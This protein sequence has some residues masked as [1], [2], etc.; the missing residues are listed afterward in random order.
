[1]DNVTTPPMNLEDAQKVLGAGDN[2]ESE[3][4]VKCY[5]M[6]IWAD[7]EN[8]E[9]THEREKL[10]SAAW[11]VGNQ[12][13][14]VQQI[15]KNGKFVLDINFNDLEGVE[16]CDA[17]K[18]AGERFKFAKKPVQVGCLKCKDVLIHLNGKD[19]IIEL[20]MITY[21]GKDV[22]D[23]ARYQRY[24]GR[25]VETC[26]SC[27]G[28]GRYITEDKEFGGKNDLECKTCHGNNVDGKSIHPVLEQPMTQIITK[29]K[30]CKGK[31]TIKIPVIS[32]E[33]KSTTI[34]R[35]CSGKG[36]I[37]PRPESMPMNPVISVDIASGIKTL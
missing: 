17:C 33:I 28:T 3:H 27:K 36:F 19:L 31:R 4:L 15:A 1:M 21:D 14:V 6:A 20:D 7:K 24:L 10:L 25:V 35:K 5:Q 11:R 9:L 22:S 29:C 16:T 30:T 37:T 18:G 2:L 13:E 12:N 34:C 8:G 23:D 32:A 26:I